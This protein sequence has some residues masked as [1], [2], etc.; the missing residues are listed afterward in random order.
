MDRPEQD[1]RDE[2]E[3]EMARD[4]GMRHSDAMSETPEMATMT[5]SSAV[6]TGRRS[7]RRAVL[8][9]LGTGA[10][11]AALAGIGLGEAEARPRG[12]AKQTKK[13][14]KRKTHG[15]MGNEGF[16]YSG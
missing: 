11:G 6:R 1:P 5:P 14:G 15:T 3:P 16:R 2:R 9:V 10:L 7:S 13:H 4:S 12:Y 8:T